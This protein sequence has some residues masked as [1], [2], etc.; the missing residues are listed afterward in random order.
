MNNRFITKAATVLIAIITSF[1]AFAQSRIDKEIARLEKDSNVEV[2]YTERRNPGNKKLIKQSIILNG[3]NK[4]QAENLWN[5]FEAE[6]VNSVSVTKQ[7]DK[8]F[9]MKF[10]DKQYH[11]SYV[12][13]VNGTNWSL[14]VTKREPDADNNFSFNYELDDLNDFNLADLGNLGQLSDLSNSLLQLNDFELDTDGNI[15]SFRDAEGNVYI[16]NTSSDNE[17]DDAIKKSVKSV[18][19]SA[20]KEAAKAASKAASKSKSNIKRT[21]TTTSK[22][23]TVITT[24]YN[25]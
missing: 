4:A 25:I 22:D 21:V 6:R 23:G 19:N 15:K 3:N 5:A 17:I 2:T 8:S 11:S 1:S 20:T 13:T 9:I 14:V 24:S 10:E 16:S 12:L 18:V 7:R